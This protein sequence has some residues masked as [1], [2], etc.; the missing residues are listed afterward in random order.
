MVCAFVPNAGNQ[1]GYS[2]PCSPLPPGTAVTFLNGSPN[3]TSPTTSDV[4]AYQVPTSPEPTNGVVLYNYQNGS[5]ASAARDA[6]TLPATE[7]SLC[8]AILNDFVTSDWR[9]R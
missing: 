3:D 9:M 1:L 2:F 7:H 6:C 5:G 8:T 4:I